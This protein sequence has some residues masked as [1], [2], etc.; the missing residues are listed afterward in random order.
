MILIKSVAN[1]RT[2]SRD[3]RYG[4]YIQAH[5]FAGLACYPSYGVRYLVSK[6]QKETFSAIKN[7]LNGFFSALIIKANYSLYYS[8]SSQSCSMNCWILM[9]YYQF[10]LCKTQLYQRW[11]HRTIRNRMSQEL[12]HLDTSAPQWE[13]WSPFLKNII[14]HKIKGKGK[15]KLHQCYVRYN[16]P[17]HRL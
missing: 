13:E 5:T 4:T 12:F 3:V 8:Q 2:G 1:Q 9:A 14:I 6:Q 16:T 7:I 17:W 10:S 15:E 11:K